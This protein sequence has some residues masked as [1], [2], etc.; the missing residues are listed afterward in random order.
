MPRRTIALL[1]AIAAAGLPACT[2]RREGPRQSI[3]VS[4]LTMTNPYFTEMAEAMKAEAAGKGF[5]VIVNDGDKSPSKQKDQVKDFLVKKVS[6]IVLSPCD[7]RSVGTAIA[8]ANEAA[9]P[10]FTVDIACLA[11]GARVVTHVA[12]D[13]LAGGRLAGQ[14]MVKLL[15]G[16]GKV[17]ILDFPVVE[18]VILRSKG[19][20]EEV[21]KAPGIA[22]VAVAEGG[23]DKAISRAAAQDILQAHQDLDAFFS[24]N[25]P[26]ALGAIAAIEEAHRSDRVKVIGFDGQPEARQAIKDGKLHA[27]ILQHPKEMGAMAIDL[28]ARYMNGEKLPGE[29]LIP[30][31]VYRKEDALKDRALK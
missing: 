15:G 16:K 20:R 26:S 21:A 13:N 12:T 28:V 3:G 9:V 8:E 25:D 31:E 27:T 11:E 29:T 14:E 6:A 30:T 18:S 5:E 10:V 24:I 17:A 2:S 23:G 7:S 1:L 22:I 4:L 19:F